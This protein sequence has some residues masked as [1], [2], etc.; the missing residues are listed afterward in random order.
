MGVHASAVSALVI[1]LHLDGAEY[2]QNRNTPKT[3]CYDPLEEYH[4]GGDEFPINAINNTNTTTTMTI[5]KKQ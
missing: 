1:E 5:V 3:S 4:S 2:L